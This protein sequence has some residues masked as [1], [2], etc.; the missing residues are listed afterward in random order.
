MSKRVKE[1]I[2]ELIKSLTKSE[3]RYFKLISSRHTIGEENNYVILF[4][5]IEKQVEYNEQALF[6]QFKGETFLNK[7]SITK[8]RLYDHILSALDLFHNSSSIEAQ[9]YKMLHSADILYDKSL[10]D[11]SKSILRSAEK[12][13]L[14]KEYFNLALIIKSK[15]K[16][17]FETSSYTEISKQEID[18]IYT[19]DLYLHN[20]SLL[21]NKLWNIKSQLFH[22]LAQKGNSR[23]LDEFSEF[24]LI[25]DELAKNVK[26]NEWYFETH[27]LFYHIY[28]AYFFAINDLESCLI[29]LQINMDYFEQHDVYIYNHSNK[30]FSILTNAIFVNEKLG[31]FKQAQF[32]FQKLKALPLKIKDA[33]NE[34][35]QIK[36]FSSISSIEINSLIQHGDFQ[37]AI[38]LIPKIKDGLV[39]YDDK[40][41]TP[42]KIYLSFK[43]AVVYLAVGD[44]V[45]ALKWINKILNDKSLDQKEDILAYTQLLNVLV[46]IEMK[47][48]DLLAYLV[49]STLR[50]LKAKNRLYEPEKAFFTFVSKLIK[51]S[52][53]FEK[54]QFWQN[55]YDVLSELF[56]DLNNAVSLDYFDLLSWTEAKFKRQSFQYIVK[57]KFNKKLSVNL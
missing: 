49:K 50:S 7:F 47:H 32:V 31:K 25:I 22:L 24:K 29:N 6:V 27:Y 57:S 42:R 38:L 23:S 54:E 43:I 21:Y 9:I 3:K 39:F 35:L 51:T 20:Q 4:D 26:E 5:A 2:H 56:K 1:S 12:L 19:I 18:E 34:D 30:Y 41:A 44:D 28:S 46:H 37:E 36:L 15:Q 10:Y 55:T 48:Y 33:T 53:V 13:A 45:N 8:K 52:D 16:R 11:Q 17:L 14:K 40:I